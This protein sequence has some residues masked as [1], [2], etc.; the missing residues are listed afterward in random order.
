MFVELMK[1]NMKLNNKIFPT[2]TNAL[3]IAA[4]LFLWFLV[5]VQDVGIT[6]NAVHDG[7]LLQQSAG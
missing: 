1:A 5:N 7:S 6:K 2:E 4:T 3:P